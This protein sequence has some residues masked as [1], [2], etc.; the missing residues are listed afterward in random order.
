MKEARIARQSKDGYEFYED[1][2]S[3]HISKDVTINF[4]QKILGID[5]KTLHGFKKILAIYA[6]KQSSYHTVNMYNRFQELIIKT[7]SSIIN[8]ETILNWKAILGTKN[9]WHLGGLKGFLLSWYEYGYYGVDKSVATLLESFTLSGNEKGKA[10]L[11]RCPYTG[12]FTDNEILALMSEL[13]RLWK[14]DLISFETYAYINLLQST[15]RRPIQIRHLKFKALRKEMSNGT[16][17]Y[18]LDI[19]TAKKRNA[20]F[21]SSFKSLSI[22]EDLYLILLN[23][24]KFY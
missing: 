8:T 17:N 11:M 1:N 4:S 16:W 5:K 15:A 7:N 19:P 24:I 18:Y 22:T 2:N 9:E 23:F 12:A 10:V 13:N 20:T 3:W 14:E 21:R 6:E